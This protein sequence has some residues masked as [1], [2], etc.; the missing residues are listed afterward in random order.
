MMNGTRYLPL[1]FL[2]AAVAAPIAAAPVGVQITG[3][4]V[5]PFAEDPDSLGE[6]A[7]QYQ[8]SSADRMFSGIEVEIWIGSVG[9]GG[10]YVARFDQ[11][12]VT[13]ADVRAETGEDT[14]WWLDQ[15]SDIF[16]SYHIFG[17]GALIDPY[18]RYGVGFAAQIDL[19]NGVYYDEESKEWSSS[20]PDSYVGSDEIRNAAIYQYL[21]AGLQTNLRGLVIG[22][23]L[24]YTVLNQ[25]VYADG[26]DWGLYPNERFEGR[27][28]GG[29]AIGGRR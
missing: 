29:V 9:F 28:Y 18:V 13:D 14:D 12:E 21:G 16:L 3:L 20:R 2:V 22:V 11:F 26:Y 27:I 25:K 17:G 15:K 23:G 6:V 8:D 10:R 7:D 19:D 4:A 5:A 24:D 1:L